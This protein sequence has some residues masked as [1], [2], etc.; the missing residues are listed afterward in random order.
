ME[1][2]DCMGLTC[3]QPVLKTRAYLLAH[4]DTT[5]FGVSVDNAA[6]SENV[7]RFLENQGFEVTIDSRGERIVITAAQTCSV[8]GAPAASTPVQKPE[9]EPGRDRGEDARTLIVIARNLLGD[10]DAALGRKLMLNFINTL[11]EMGSALWRVVCLNAGVK[12]TIEGAE[13]LPGLQ[14]LVDEG[15]SLLVCGTCLDHYRLLESKRVGE[16]TNMLDIVT[17]LQHAEKVITI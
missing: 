14:R 4:P 17:S 15:V 11:P 12:L 9:F 13:T 16:T 1:I 2:I 7:K 10:G 3:P 5:G 8:P 6:A